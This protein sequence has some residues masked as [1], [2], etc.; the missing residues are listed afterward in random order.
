MRDI[1][2]VAEQ[3]G[4][5]EPDL[6]L[7]GRYRAKIP[8]DALPDPGGDSSSPRG[9]YVLV[10]AVTPTPAGEGKTVSAIGLSMGLNRIGKNAAVVLRQSS[11]GPTLGLKGGGAGGGISRIEPLEESLIG[12]GSDLFA[13]ESA[14][15]LL[16]ALIDDALM[17]ESVRVDPATITWRRVIDMDDRGLRQIVTG[18]GGKANGVLRETGFDITAAS[19]VMAVL[20]LSRDLADLRRR[21]AA[22]VIGF[23]EDGKPVTAEAVRGPGAM[24][25]LLRDAIKPNL[26]QTS[27]GTPALIHTG[28]FGNI[29]HG[30]SSV[31][32]DLI[33]LPRLEYLVTEAGFG[34]DMGA[35]KLFHIKAPVSGLVPDAVVVVTTVR[36]LKYHSGRFDAIPGGH[37]S[38]EIQQEDPGAVEAGASNLDRHVRNMR[39]L[40]VPVVVAINRFPT[41]HPSEL[42]AVRQAGSAAGALAVVEHSAF[43]DGGAGAEA[44]ASAVE[45]ACGQPSSFVPLYRPEQPLR[46]KV[47]AL[48][49]RMYGAADVKWDRAAE[50]AVDRFTA[51]GYG[52]LPVCMAKTH[53]SISHDPSLKGAPSGYVF[54]I[55]G[56]RLSAGAGFVYV[57]AGDIVTMP[58]L[59]SHSHA[60]EIDLDANGQ[61]IGLV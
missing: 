25:M 13:V 15:N 54:P 17:R 9:K 2:Q 28:P 7:H 4:F 39:Q 37:A 24:A 34:A 12:L 59:P 48:A 36:A 61:T 58:G 50:L 14:N 30:N 38:K 26:M 49:T 16:A 44:L 19:E 21:L 33:A 22:I 31:V 3:L 45:N 40:G 11:L 35:E 5:G 51:A 42:A 29:A 53:L 10:T 1:R 47:H 43:A 32:A 23:E 6:E 60:A 56:A 57:L 20:G 52:T 55:R 8:L 41:D 46:E 27:E 18:L